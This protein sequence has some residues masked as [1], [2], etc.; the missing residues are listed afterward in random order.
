MCRPARVLAEAC[1]RHCHMV[2]VGEAGL[3]SKHFRTI[4]GQLAENLEIL[5]IELRLLVIAAL[6]WDADARAKCRQYE[7]LRLKL[8]TNEKDGDPEWLLWE[9]GHALSAVV[10]SNDNLSFLDFESIVNTFTLLVLP[11]NP[12]S[13]GSPLRNGSAHLETWSPSSKVSSLP[14]PTTNNFTSLSTLTI[15][16]QNLISLL[17]LPEPLPSAPPPK[18]NLPHQDVLGLIVITPLTTVLHLLAITGL[19]KTHARN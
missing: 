15:F 1:Q 5:G 16:L 3:Y 19:T 14:I 4:A 12:T 13:T 18:H 7:H 10:E 8:R 17:Q 9:V 6:V 2:G 11:L